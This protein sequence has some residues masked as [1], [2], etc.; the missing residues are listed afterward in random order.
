MNS[1]STSIDISEIISRFLFNKK[2]YAATLNRVK[3]NA[4]L[5]AS[6]GETSVYRVS[7]LSE[8]DRLSIG[9]TVS[10]QRRKILHGRAEVSM[11]TISEVGLTVVP[12]PRPHP[13]HANIINWP[14]EKS[15]QKLMAIK[16]ADDSELC[17]I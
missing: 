10:A 8:E 1:P 4:F 2:E 3:Y 13:L 16:V 7:T 11:F 6:S 17:L 12:D 5:P 14:S 9:R 15:E